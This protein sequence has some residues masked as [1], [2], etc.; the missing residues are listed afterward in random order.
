MTTT[1]SNTQKTYWQIRNDYNPALPPEF[2]NAKG[3][4]WIV[5]QKCTA[6]YNKSLIGDIELHS[7]LIRRNPYLDHFV[8]FVN[9]VRTKYKKYQYD[10]DDKM[11]KIWFT[12]MNGDYIQVDSFV[13]ET[14]LIF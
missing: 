12:D 13:L 7:T 14:L 10:T 9:E 11:F 2:I 6:K 1:Q 5:V 4:K 3:P 8:C